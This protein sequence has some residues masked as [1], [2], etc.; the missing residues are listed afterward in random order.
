VAPAGLTA[1]LKVAE[2]LARFATVIEEQ[3]ADVADGTV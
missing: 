2:E 3:T 1:I